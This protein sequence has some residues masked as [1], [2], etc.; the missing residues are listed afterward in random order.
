MNRGHSV[1]ALS[2][3]RGSSASGVL[4]EMELLHASLRVGDQFPGRRALMLKLGASE[5]AVTRAL[6][7]LARQGKIVKRLGRG[8]SVVAETHTR[9]PERNG[10]NPVGS[11]GTATVSSHH[12]DSRMVVAI[13]EPDGSVFDNAMQLLLKQAKYSDLTVTCRLMHEEE[14]GH[15]KAPAAAVG[16][17]GYI[18]FRRHFLDLATRLQAA[19][20][21]VVFVGTP[22]ADTPVEVPNVFG[23]QEHG[24]YLAVKHLLDLGHRRIAFHFGGDYAHLRR[25][26]GCLQA[27]EEARCEG[28][29]IHTEMLEL[30]YDN[31]EAVAG[32][33]KGFELVRAYFARPEAPTA[34]VSWNDDTAIKLLTLL[35]RAGIRVPEDVSLIG[36]DNLA[37]GAAVHPALTTIDGV[38]DQQIQAAL[39][40]LTQPAAP[41]GNQSTVV[42][43]TLIQRESTAQPRF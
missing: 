17:R 40:L 30:N 14:A 10:S 5:R 39:R 32:W 18:V 15:F 25:W 3:K 38:L 26:T 16:P 4:H 2:E 43:P 12:N 41:P 36:Y 27:L 6:D 1:S 21:R 23:D 22:Y 37:R 31:S 8:G 7:E 9:E 34:I 33:G 29:E 24:G 11:N 19:G 20:N 28:Q 13:G 35:L 42:L